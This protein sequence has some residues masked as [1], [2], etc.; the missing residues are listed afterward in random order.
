LYISASARVDHRAVLGKDLRIWD[1]AHI[2]E[3]SSIGDGCVIGENV[4]VGSG[5]TLG[6]NCKVQNNALIY[7]GSQIHSGVFIGPG[8]I[9]T[10]DQ[11]PR[12]VNSD[13]TIK[14]SG[15]WNKVGVMVEEGASIG[16]G[17]ILVAPLLVG[18]WSLIGAGAVVTKDVKKF[19]LVVGNP[20]RQIGWVGKH[21]SSLREIGKNQFVCAH[22]QT[23]YTVSNGDLVEE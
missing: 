2:R 4:Y 10:N 1:N 7:E 21:G 6:M 18:S 8:A 15:D 12:A 11:F 22:T 13:S 17:A 23:V 14:L 16:A 3:D 9:L 19:A 20:A 5:V